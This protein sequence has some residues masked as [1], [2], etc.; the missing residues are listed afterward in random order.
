[1]LAPNALCARIFDQAWLRDF[2][3]A[4]VSGQEN[5][6]HQLWALLSLEL[7]NQRWSPQVD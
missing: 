7:W 4:H 3:R 6:A 1:V 5:F 2:V